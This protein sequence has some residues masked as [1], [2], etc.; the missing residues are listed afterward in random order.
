MSDLLSR[1]LRFEQ[2][3]NRT[4]ILARELCRS[5]RMAPHFLVYSLLKPVGDI[6]PSW[7][8]WWN[9]K[10]QRRYQLTMIHQL[11]LH[12]ITTLLPCSEEAFTAGSAEVG[13]SLPV[14]TRTGP[15]QDASPMVLA[16]LSGQLL[17]KIC[18]HIQMTTSSDTNLDNDVFWQQNQQIRHELESAIRNMPLRLQPTVTTDTLALHVSTCLYSFSI[19]LDQVALDLIRD[20]IT[21]G[22]TTD[23]IRRR[24][25]H[26]AN[27]IVKIIDI[28]LQ[29][30]IGIHRVRANPTIAW[31]I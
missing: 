12:Q 14:V 16:V 13:P 29:K 27:A 24:Q 22:Y 3:A 8:P 25:R 23:H 15:S 2:M 20:Q 6:W 18:K 9:D 10:R 7:T 5:R 30:G 1:Q 28:A 21:Q 4:S 26:A 11:T 19:S 31:K 17:E